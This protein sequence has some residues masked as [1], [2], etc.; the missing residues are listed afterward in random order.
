M[1]NSVGDRAIVLIPGLEREER[2]QR[3]NILALNFK[4]SA[5]RTPVQSDQ[6]IE[7]AGESGLALS[8]DDYSEGSAKTRRVDLFEAYW[9]DMVIDQTPETPLRRIL[10]G[11]QLLIYWFCSSVWQAFGISRYMTL[12]LLASGVLLLLW[13]FSVVVLAA[14]AIMEAPE[15]AEAGA[16]AGVFAHFLQSAAE[17]IAGL[18][19]WRFWTVLVGFLGAVGAD[20]I[21][22]VALFGKSYLRNEINDTGTGLRDRVGE[23]V[24][25]TLGN[26]YAA[27]YSEVIVLAHSFGTVIAIDVLA[28]YPDDE[29]LKRTRLVTW[30][31]PVAVL[32]YRSGWLTDE[33]KR[34]LERPALSRWDDYH[35]PYD[36]LCTAVPGHAEAHVGESVPLRLDAFWL[37]GFSAGTHE[38]YYHTQGALEPLLTF[39][40]QAPPA[41]PAPDPDG[42]GEG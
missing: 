3:R 1:G 5:S 10:Q 26:V 31:S 32:G 41:S 39:R 24:R 4:S 27:G 6:D 40:K 30:G 25:A 20:R 21:A 17:P 19:D 29:A 22:Q 37:Q 23:R 8:V 7:V 18:T 16:E 36:W 12:W 28:D 34:L 15:Q 9:G 13:Y 38:L 33:C 35:A 14:S 2:N 42:A 11:L